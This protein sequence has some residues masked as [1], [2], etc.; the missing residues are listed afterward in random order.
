MVCRFEKTYK[1]ATFS[2]RRFSRRELHHCDRIG[3]AVPKTKALHGTFDRARRMVGRNAVT[4]RLES[5][6]VER[7]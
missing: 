5:D 2:N 1:V 7:D 3:A 4:R 6:T